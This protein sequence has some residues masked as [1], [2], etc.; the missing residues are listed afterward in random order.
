MQSMKKMDEYVR[1][2]VHVYTRYGRV[3]PAMG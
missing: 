2:Y 1:T 3:I